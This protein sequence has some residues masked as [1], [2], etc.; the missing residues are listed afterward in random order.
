MKNKKPILYDI[1]ISTGIAIILVVTGHL[2]LRGENDI[3][4]YVSLKK[5]I[6]KFHMPLFLFLSGSITYYTYKPLKS[7]KSYF[8]FV[9]KKAYRL[10]PAYLLLSILF[11]VGK[12]MFYDIDVYHSFSSILFYP[13]EGNSGFLWYIYVLFIFN[14]SMPLIHYVVNSR[15]WI[16]LFISILTSSFLTFPKIFTLNF[17]F[18]YLP[19]FIFGCYSI[20]KREKFI[21]FLK[22]YGLLFLII[23][24]IWFLLEL[25]EDVNIPKNI[26]SF[27][28]I[29][30]ISYF[31]Y[32]II[33]RNKFLE[34][35][36]NNSFYIYLFNSL[37]IG[38]VTFMIIYFF[39]RETFYNNFYYFIPALIFI[40]ISFPILF[41][42]IIIS[43]TPILKNLIK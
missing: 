20:L 36:G 2:A 1:K 14:L 10:L 8:E 19:F 17:Y 18:W 5:V 31:S 42:K 16:F 34:K 38:G 3:D 24:L 28:S 27:F 4:F 7:W 11:F 43:K 12:F 15:F 21:L 41:H 32:F 37:F 30:G 9:K 22:K 13:Q 25:N 39:G 40:G 35:S 23:F 6:Y 29:I 33:K 26:V